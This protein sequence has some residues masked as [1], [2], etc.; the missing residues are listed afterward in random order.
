MTCLAFCVFTTKQEDDLKVSLAH[1]GLAL[2]F[3]SSGIGCRKPRALKAPEVAFL[4]SL[5]KIRELFPG[6]K[7]GPIGLKKGFLSSS[8]PLKGTTGRIHLPGESSNNFVHTEP[9]P[10]PPIQDRLRAVAACWGA[11]PWYAVDSHAA[12]NQERVNRDGS[13]P[14]ACRRLSQG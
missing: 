6:N 14:V 9:P 12:K 1:L 4:S 5:R 2:T 10:T 3:A 13:V 11:P 8:S 7:L